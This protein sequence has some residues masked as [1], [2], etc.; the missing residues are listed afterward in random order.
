MAKLPTDDGPDTLEEQAVAIDV[1]WPTLYKLIQADA[2][3]CPI[4]QL[5]ATLAADDAKAAVGNLFNKEYNAFSA[6]A[7][8][9]G[10]RCNRGT[11][12]TFAELATAAAED[13]GSPPTIYD[14]EHESPRTRSPP[15][16]S[17]GR[18]RPL[19]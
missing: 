18:P 11:M 8:A 16:S 6:F 17:L 13:S 14:R 4:E 5:L 19:L 15:C 9:H 1:A 2:F 10:V 12:P 3:G 7:R